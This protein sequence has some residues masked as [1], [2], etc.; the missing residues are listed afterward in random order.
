MMN[1]INNP[2]Y[3]ISEF[4][5]EVLNDLQ[6]AEPA[7]AP[8]H[9]SAI[10][11]PSLDLENH[12]NEEDLYL[13]LIRPASPAFGFFSSPKTPRSHSPRA[14][15]GSTLLETL[16]RDRFNQLEQ[17]VMPMLLCSHEY[18]YEEY[19]T[20]AFLVSHL[21]TLNEKQKI[22]GLIEEA[23]KNKKEEAKKDRKNNQNCNHD[24]FLTSLK[25]W[26]DK[27]VLEKPELKQYDS[28][29][30][31]SQLHHDNPNHLK[32]ILELYI[33]QLLFEKAYLSYLNLPHDAIFR[34]LFDQGFALYVCIQ[35]KKDMLLTEMLSVLG[36][37]LPISVK[38]CNEYAE[39]I[40]DTPMNI[41]IRQ[42]MTD[43]PNQQN[44]KRLALVR[45][46]RFYLSLSALSTEGSSSWIMIWCEPI[47]RVVMAWLN[48][49]FFLPRIIIAITE[50]ATH[51]FLLGEHTKEEKKLTQETRFMMFFSR[52]WE[53]LF[54][55]FAWMLNGFLSL[56]VLVGVLG[57]WSLYVNALVQLFEVFL[58]I[59][60]I[61]RFEEHQHEMIDYFQDAS[62]AVDQ[63]ISAEFM[64]DVTSRLNLEYENRAVRLIN[65]II[66]LTASMMILPTM[67]A[68]S[69]II[70]FVGAVIALSV[71]I[72]HFIY[73]P[74]WD[75]RRRQKLEPMMLSKDEL[76][77]YSPTKYDSLDFI[78]IF[79]G[80]SLIL[81]MTNVNLYIP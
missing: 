71:S 64:E 42:A 25:N 58:N 8:S 61:G 33:Y 15:A 80:E 19:K 7:Q 41:S 45:V 31:M 11:E 62:L 81:E 2:L 67:A 10:D 4:V 12:H 47:F 21:T 3:Y 24:I 75:D 13:H 69:P 59:F 14:F 53:I 26:K 38:Y 37:N 66:I 76:S 78:N 56:F 18:Y 74:D 29:Q 30:S 32:K 55:D 20:L 46:R 72:F 16:I 22:F 6:R 9:I 79:A 65:S 40:Q 70:P 51:T 54:R 44:A 17:K 27:I 1:N 23:K 77:G 43:Q 48:F 28:H 68:I 49:I 35:F 39:F 52:R 73:F 34:K 36:E 5:E 57:F 63:H 60:V 50:I